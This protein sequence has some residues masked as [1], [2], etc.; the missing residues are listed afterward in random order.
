MNR[1]ISNESGTDFGPS[2]YVSSCHA[3][4]GISGACY[5]AGSLP[6]PSNSVSYYFNYSGYNQV[7]NDQVGTLIWNQP[8]SDGNGTVLYES[9]SAGLVYQTNSNVAAPLFGFSQVAFLVGFDSKGRLFGYNYVDDS[10]FVAGVPPT[11]YKPTGYCEW[12]FMFSI[13]VSAC[14]RICEF[15]AYNLA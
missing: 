12:T 6:E 3:G 13:L 5:G 9:Q 2:G 11:S 15:D 1:S 10:K 8:Y 4:A 7:G 14:A